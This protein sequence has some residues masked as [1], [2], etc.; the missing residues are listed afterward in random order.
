MICKYFYP[1]CLLAILKHVLLS[2]STPCPQRG[3]YELQCALPPSH[4]P[5]D[6][7]SYYPWFTYCT[8]AMR[9]PRQSSCLRPLRYYSLFSQKSPRLPHLHNTFAQMKVSQ[10][11]C[12]CPPPL[13]GSHLSN[14]ELFALI[15]TWF[16]SHSFPA[17][18]PPPGC[19]S[20]K[21]RFY[22]WSTAV[23]SASTAAS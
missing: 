23:S 10:Q 4:Y 21:L 17:P 19:D 6:L 11:T 5:S 18:P 13:I 1:L 7:I 12:P 16:I 20:F 15:P 14:L 3:H 8:P 2:A 9:H 22:V